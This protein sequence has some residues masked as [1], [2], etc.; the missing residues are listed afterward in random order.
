MKTNADY[1]KLLQG[2]EEEKQQTREEI[3]YEEKKKE[4]EGRINTY[5]NEHNLI[6]Y[7]ASETVYSTLV[8]IAERELG[9][10]NKYEYEAVIWA[11][12]VTMMHEC[13]IRRFKKKPF[14]FDKSH[15][16]QFI[17]LPND[18][19]M[20][21]AIRMATARHLREA[22]DGRAEIESISH[23]GDGAYSINVTMPVDYVTIDIKL[24]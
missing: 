21:D 7:G 9:E 11:N 3:K 5:I 8:E 20:M 14:G 4:L 2:S 12:P 1:A 13:H 19:N 16:D 22:Y 23:G 15:F 6:R 10:T 18:D 24:E 17:G